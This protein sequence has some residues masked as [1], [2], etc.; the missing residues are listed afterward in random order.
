M[1]DKHKIGDLVKL[2]SGGPWMT[3]W[4][5]RSD[6]VYDVEWFAGEHLMRDAFSELELESQKEWHD[7]MIA[8]YLPRLSPQLFVK[9]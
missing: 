8:T 9:D 5:R 6:E 7:R 4:H 2:R 3:V 1:T